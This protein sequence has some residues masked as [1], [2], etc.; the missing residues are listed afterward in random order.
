VLAAST[1]W[2]ADSLAQH[3]RGAGIA[4]QVRRGE[5]NLEDVFVAATRKPARA[6]T[7]TA[8]TGA[9]A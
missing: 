9:A 3:L 5:P 8:A 6:A 1:A 4:A 2:D 7:G